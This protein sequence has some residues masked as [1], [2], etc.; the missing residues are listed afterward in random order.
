MNVSELLNLTTWI[1]EKVV[2]AQIVK[3]Y[4][5]LHSILQQNSQ[6]NQQ[7]QP[8]ES[9]KDELITILGGVNLDGLTKDQLNFLNNLGIGNAVG[10][11]GIGLVE[12]VLFKNVIDVAT[13]AQKVEEIIKRINEG[14]EKSNQIKAGI[15]NCTEEEA[16]EAEDEVLMRI[17]F[18]GKASMSSV[19]DFKSWGNI[20]YDIFRGIAMLHNLSPEN[21]KIIGATQG[22]I[23]L[24]L[25]VIIDIATTASGIILAALR[26]TEKV[27]DIRMKAEEIREL[28]LKNIKLAKDLEKEAENEKRIGIDE[29]TVRLVNKFSLDQNNQGD[30][31]TALD[32]AI[33]NL[34]DFVEMGGEVDFV[35]SDG[36][37]SDDKENQKEKH[38]LRIVFQE[39]RNLERKLSLTESRRDVE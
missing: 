34:V 39:I 10:E 25:A 27:L 8:F 5:A 29:I 9:Q 16:Y 26:V 23:V 35:M 19:T 12:D 20:W 7:K 32:K 13:S 6:P 22:S 36:K 11:A 2:K 4:E 17:A 15:E 28:K 37:K 31:V 14:I 21:V 33:N 38:E 30:K 24:E 1:D 18:T 3:K